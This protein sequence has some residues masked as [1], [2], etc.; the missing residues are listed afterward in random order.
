[1][2]SCY[3]RWTKLLGR[4]RK[5]ERGNLALILALTALP[6]I[7]AAGAAVDMDRVML[8]KSKYNSYADT[9]ALVAANQISGVTT[10]SQA[11]AN[12]ENAFKAN[13]VQN[14]FGTITS[15]VATVTDSSGKRTVTLTY[16]VAVKMTFMGMVGAKTVNIGGTS[17]VVGGTPLYSDF[18]VLLDNTPSMGLAATTTDIKNLE[19]LTKNSVDGQCAF[20]C[21]VVNT[22]KKGIVT[23]N[24]N[25]PDEDFYPTATSNNITLRIDTVK[26]AVSSMIT[27][28]QTNQTALTHFRF[29]LYDFGKSAET[30]ALTNV[31][32]LNSN[33]AQVSSDAGKIGLMTVP[34]QNYNDDSQSDLIS[35][36]TAMSNIVPA[37]GD[38]STQAKSQKYL[39]F[40]SDGVNDS[41]LTGSNKCNEKLSQYDSS[42]CQEPVSP[43]LCQA[44]K[45][46]NV[47][48]VAI[49]TTYLPVSSKYA[50]FIDNSWY[51]AYV[52][53]YN[54]GPFSPSPNSKIAQNMKSCA[55]PGYYQ[56]VGPDDSIS[57]V[58]NQMFL[59]ILGAPR[60][61]S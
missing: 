16:S 51:D 10:T 35:V 33:L 5:S 46:N 11:K 21:H 40:V 42:R 59:K 8:E 12:A 17:T 32:A 57:S 38:G 37:S 36:L 56:E 26:S 19:N 44:L 6:V 55:S 2:V 4:F 13:A 23:E 41:L 28:A 61:A 1:M 7:V 52:D 30:A 39:F 31:S 45:N 48:V 54:N 14:D 24:H 25:S 29:S 43:A 18:Y 15:A 27:T 20:A 47:T 53:P 34:Y 22:D 60:I 50:P 3:S 9:A 49:Y 58:L